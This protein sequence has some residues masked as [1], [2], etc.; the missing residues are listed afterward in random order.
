MLYAHLLIIL[1]FWLLY[2]E[3]RIYVLLKTL[4]TDHQINRLN[5]YLMMV[6]FKLFTNYNIEYKFVLIINL[7][8]LSF[9]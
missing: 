5:V 1:F 4:S 2:N 8:F 3:N 7:L 6:M 9:S